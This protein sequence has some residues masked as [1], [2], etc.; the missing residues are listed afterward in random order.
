MFSPTPPPIGDSPP[1]NSPVIGG[2]QPFQKEE[3]F[4]YLY[5]DTPFFSLRFPAS[6]VPKSKLSVALHSGTLQLVTLSLQL[7]L[8]ENR[9]SQ[10]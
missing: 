9:Q 10:S 4:R 2:E 1:L 8:A 3:S 7:E 6:S 5:F